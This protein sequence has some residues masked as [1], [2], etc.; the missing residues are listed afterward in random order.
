MRCARC[1]A[2]LDDDAKVCGQCGAVVGATYAGQATKPFTARTS[3]RAFAGTLPGLASR[4]KGIIA[5]PASEWTAIA[6]EPTTSFEVLTGYAAPLAAIGAL[7]LFVGQVAVGLAVPMIGIVRAGML[8]GFVT[9]MLLFVLS[10][11][12]VMALGAIVNALAPRFGGQRS[13]ARA[14]KLAA[15]SHTPLWLAGIAYALPWIGFLWILAG[16]YAV[17][18]AALGLPVMMRCPT[19]RAPAYAIVT[20]VC[21][22]VLFAVAGSTIAALTG[23]GPDL[24]D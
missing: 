14:F 17:Y 20:A 7:A 15:Y 19:E 11:L 9:A 16:L 4:V 13:G 5:H 23:F 6:S 10:L 3:V 8:A 1:G 18:V 12:V 22:F 24:F 21:G 2:T